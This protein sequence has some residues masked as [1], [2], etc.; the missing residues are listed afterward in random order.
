MTLFTSQS[1]LETLLNHRSIRKFTEQAIDDSIFDTL[2]QAGLAGS[3]SG[4]LQ[5]ASIIRVTDKALRANIRRI[6]ANVT[7]DETVPTSHYGHAY[8]EHC[9]E[10]LVFCMD[11]QR[12]QTLV[13]TLQT[14]WT[15]VTLVGAID[16][17]IM[18]QNILVTAESLGLGGVYIGSVRNDIDKLSQLLQ[19]PKHVVPLFGMCL[20]HP[21]Q[22][23]VIRPRLP[24]N[25]V[26][27]TNHY[28]PADTAQLHAYNDI[29]K[30]YYAERGQVGMDWI[31][32]IQTYL[33]QPSRPQI[34]PYLNQQ[35]YAKR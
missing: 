26:V 9:A 10:F 20:G 28:Q 34:L 21:A 29:M 14:D 35:G 24:S 32:Q 22:N 7:D 19:L 15:E 3:S 8:V 4:F 12:H 25:L 16:S 27:S 6:C 11:N 1:A 18:A 5:S 33:N 13:P 23:P 31:K 30:A 2:I 17:A